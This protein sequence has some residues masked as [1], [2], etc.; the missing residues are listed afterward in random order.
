MIQFAKVF[1]DEQILVSLIRELSWTHLPARFP[2]AERDLPGEGPWSGDPA[3]DGT[4][5]HGTGQRVRLPGQ[6]EAEQ[7]TM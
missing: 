6:A 2:W 7:G 3:R 4:L 5:H 1:P